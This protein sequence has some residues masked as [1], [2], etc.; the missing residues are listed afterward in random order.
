MNFDWTPEQKDLQQRVAAVLDSATLAEI[1][2]LEHA[3]PGSFAGTTRQLLG[4]LAEAGYFDDAHRRPILRLAAQEAL[5]RA[6][7]SLFLAAEVSVTLFGGLLAT[8]IE[9][10]EARPLLGALGTGKAI[11]AVATNDGPGDAT[12]VA[13]CTGHAD[14]DGLVVSGRK[15]FVTN[16]PIADWFAVVVTMDEGPRQAVCV[17]EA[18]TEGLTVGSRIDT[19]GHRGLAVGS[20]QLDAVRVRRTHVMGPFEGPEALANLRR[21]EDLLLAV[22]AVGLAQRS[23]HAAR[24]HAR[25]HERD[26]KPIIRRQ[27]MAFTLAEML[28]LVETAQWMV[29]RAAWLC[30]VD[31]PE[32]STVVQCAKVF[33][34]EAAERVAR[35]GL[36]VL[37]GQ[38]YRSGSPLE[39]AHREACLTALSGTTSERARMAIAADLI[40]RSPV[41]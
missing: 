10:D 7:G 1:E 39:R 35:S 8:A 34:G 40:A 27:Q 36:Q 11:G 32:A 24:A 13:T 25:S 3:E 22:G 23:L 37:A 5:A 4:Q 28:T 2:S 20:L 33:A 21:Q 12:T 18:A 14:G 6:S 19:L 15:P 41:E 16:G 30:S 17:L 29:R 38:G 31:D 26:G 9:P